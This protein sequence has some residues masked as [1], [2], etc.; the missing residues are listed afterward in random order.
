MLG[1][2]VKD[3]VKSSDGSDINPVIVGRKKKTRYFN[4][5]INEEFFSK[6]VS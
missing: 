1:T 4:S 5:A 3:V 2:I 6:R